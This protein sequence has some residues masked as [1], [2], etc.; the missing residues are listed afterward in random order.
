[1]GLKESDM[2]ERLTL[3]GHPRLEIEIL[4]YCTLYSTVQQ[5][6]QNPITCKGYMGYMTKYPQTRELTCMTGRVNA[7]SH[8]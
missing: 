8:L 3:S 7:G 4:N 6:T 2:T 5:Y 1:M